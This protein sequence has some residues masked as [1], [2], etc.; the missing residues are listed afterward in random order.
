MFVEA[1]VARRILNVAGAVLGILVLA[2]AVPAEAKTAAERREELALI[3]ERMADPDPLM[4]LA[5]LEEY[6]EAEDQ[7]L[8]M[9]AVRYALASD[10]EDLRAVA[11]RIYVGG[12]S[13]LDLEMS[14]PKKF[15]EMLNSDKVEEKVKEE[16]RSYWLYRGLY[17]QRVL[18]LKILDYDFSS[19]TIRVAAMNQLDKPEERFSGDGQ[20]RGTTL[21]ISTR[22]RFGA[23]NRSFEPRCQIILS[24]TRDL[25][26]TGYAACETG[27]EYPEMLLSMRMF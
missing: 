25:M 1:I 7:T 4:R 3:R 24:P 9:L 6:A 8:T 2:L 14:L 17:N 16:L 21:S 20:V 22:V 18:R 12:L 11:F 19:G 26:L 10:D 15:V 5:Y 13:S 23:G 27:S